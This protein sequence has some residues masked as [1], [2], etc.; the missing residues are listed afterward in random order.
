MD[1]DGG[2]D[3]TANL[4]LFSDLILFSFKEAIHLTHSHGSLFLSWNDSACEQAPR[5]HRKTAS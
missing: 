4:D 2:G 3:K 1:P 5:G